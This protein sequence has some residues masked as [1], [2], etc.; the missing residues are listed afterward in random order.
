MI[1]PSLL[2]LS[3]YADKALS[4]E[5]QKAVDALLEEN[6]LSREQLADMQNE[7]R[8]LEAALQFQ[9]DGER[10]IAI[11]KFKRPLTLRGFALMNIG[12]GLVLWLAQ[13]LWK[14]LFGEFLMDI[15]A[16][17]SSVYLPDTYE[18]FVNSI[19]YFLE[20]G[21]AMFDAY[22]SYVVLIFVIGCSD[23]CAIV[24]P[25]HALVCK[26]CCSTSGYGWNV[27]APPSAEALEMRSDEQGVLTVAASEV[28]DDTLLIAAQTIRIEG[29]VTGTVLAAAAQNIEVSGRIDGNLIAAAQNITVRGSVGQL[30]IGASSRLDIEGADVAGD[31]IYAGE[32]LVI[33]K[34]AKVGR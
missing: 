32:R 5:E 13:F 6:E 15:T 11:P 17:I 19:L 10:E 18:L 1:P 2:Q 4:E 33:D 27:L 25:P 24:G 8:S 22:L 29:H 14:T 31:T 34:E 20:E 23:G 28:I 21:T 26:Y 16:R 9:L 3:M 30:L 7:A 12:T